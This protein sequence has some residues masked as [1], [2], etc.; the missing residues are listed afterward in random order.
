MSSAGLP[1][2]G[3]AWAGPLAGGPR[4][5]LAFWTR[6]KIS[7]ELRWRPAASWVQRAIS[8]AVWGAFVPRLMLLALLSSIAIELFP[9][10]AARRWPGFW[11]GWRSQTI[12]A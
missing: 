12:E 5:T 4:F 9:V 11:W 6:A 7:E 1:T 2:P 8:H 3:T 10:V